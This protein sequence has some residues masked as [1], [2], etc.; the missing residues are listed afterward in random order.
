MKIY[1]IHREVNINNRDLESE[2]MWATY[3]REEAERDIQQLEIDDQAKEWIFESKYRIEE[4]DLFG[5]KEAILR[6][7]GPSLAVQMIQAEVI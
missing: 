7:A 2:I 4:I 5:I 1:L 6:K 3:S